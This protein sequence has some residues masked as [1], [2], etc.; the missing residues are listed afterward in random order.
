[1]IFG[2][3]ERRSLFPAEQPEIPAW[4]DIA[5][6]RVW[7]T[8]GTL[9]S[10][11]M[12]SVGFLRKNSKLDLVNWRYPNFVLVLVLQGEGKYIDSQGLIYD[13]HAGS[14][15]VRIPN[16][17]HTTVHPDNFEYLECYLE[18]APQLFQ[19]L[20]SLQVLDL[21]PPVQEIDPA[22]LEEFAARA[23]N[24]G[25]KL[26]NGD[27]E[28]YSSCLTDM[29]GLL[30]DFQHCKRTASQGEKYSDLV[31]LACYWLGR[32]FQKDFSLQK[33]CRQHS[34]GYENF[35]KLF[36]QRIGVAPIN[37]R[38]NCKLESAAIMLRNSALTIKDI[39][40]Q[41]GYNTPYEFSAQFKKKFGI[42]PNIYRKNC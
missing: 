7:R 12:L 10:G 42:A 30:A 22:K 9:T 11:E 26:S 31:E 16:I 39:A 8:P 29:I 27:E 18:I 4:D 24:L 38:I 25:W 20:N 3:L 1:M 13:L 21:T 14:Y 2:E 5:H 40:G 37:Y 23:W 15:F 35:R 41:L 19:A 32:D 33:F 6:Y 36:R 28:L 34:V 17:E